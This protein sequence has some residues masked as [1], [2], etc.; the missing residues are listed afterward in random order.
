GVARPGQQGTIRRQPATA[1]QRMR[2]ASILLTVI[3]FAL[4]APAQD[5]GAAPARALFLKGRYD[6]AAERFAGDVERDVAAAV[7]LARCKLATGKRA[8]AEAVLRA[9][10]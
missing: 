3:C 4:R 8:E 1:R 5:E 6:E 7:G 9:A 10:R 2:R